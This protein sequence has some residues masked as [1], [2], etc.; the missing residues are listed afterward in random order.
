[1]KKC[2]KTLQLKHPDHGQTIEIP[3]G[4]PVLIHVAAMHLDE[5]YFENPEQFIPQ[6]FITS[7]AR[8]FNEECILLTFGGGPRVC[9]G[10]FFW[11]FIGRALSFF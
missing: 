2:I 1:M 11:G 10:E 9:L 5:A 3:E 4:T 6:R 8:K 7:Y